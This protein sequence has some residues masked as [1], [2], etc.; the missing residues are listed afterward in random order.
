MLVRRLLPEAMTWT[1]ISGDCVEVM[2]SMEPSSIDAVVTDPPYQLLF[3]G[4]GLGPAKRS[5]TVGGSGPPCPQARGHLLSFGGT[6]TYHRL[7]CALEDAGFEIRDCLAWLYGSGFPK[8]HNLTDE[9]QGWGTALKPAFEPIVL[10]RKPLSGT[11]ARMCSARHRRVERG[12]HA[13]RDGRLQPGRHT[14]TTRGEPAL[15]RWGEAGR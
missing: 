13:D 14:A 11:V 4:E 1:L 7:V 8:S 5:P 3:H 15:C 9:W 12:R 10:A 2:S 6:R